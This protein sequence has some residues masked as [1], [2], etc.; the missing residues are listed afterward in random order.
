MQH[1]FCQVDVLDMKGD[2]IGS[3]QR[4]DLDKL[5]DVFHSLHILLI[6]PLGEV[7]MSMIPVRED[8][9]N[10][11]GGKLGT[12]VSTVKRTGESPDEG[13]R[14][15]ISRELFIDDMPLSKSGVV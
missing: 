7:I 3:K 10:V 1:D 15:A 14:R 11:Y 13:A 4:K 9:P 2:I 12:T 8:L 5:T 6:T